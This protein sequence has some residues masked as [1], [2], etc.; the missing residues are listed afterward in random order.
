MLYL[1]RKIYVLLYRQKNGQH[2]TMLPAII[3][4]NSYYFTINFDVVVPP[5]VSTVTI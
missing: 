1:L 2:Q 3:I 5:S 4:L